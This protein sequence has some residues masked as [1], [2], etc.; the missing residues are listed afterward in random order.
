[1]IARRVSITGKV[2]G[3]FFRK[4]TQEEARA[5]GVIGWVRNCD[6]GSVEAHLEGEQDAVDAL[7]DRLRSGPPNAKVDALDARAVEPEGHDGFAV[8]H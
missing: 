5:L 6:D 4:T 2:Q 7:I 1:M 3:V 8:R